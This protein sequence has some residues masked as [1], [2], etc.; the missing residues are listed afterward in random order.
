MLWESAKVLGEHQLVLGRH[1]GVSAPVWW[2]RVTD[3]ITTVRSVGT[4]SSRPGLRVRG[5]QLLL[6]LSA[7]AHL[8]P[9]PRDGFH[10]IPDTSAGSQFARWAPGQ[11][12]CY[13]GMWLMG[14][15]PVPTSDSSS[16]STL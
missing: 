3:A 2:P 14:T 12:L 13:P 15:L 10:I 1:R 7:M 6:D 5:Y 4:S 9:S 11:C 16:A 8:L